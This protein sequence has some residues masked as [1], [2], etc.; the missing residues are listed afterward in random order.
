MELDNFSSQMAQSAIDIV[1]PVLENALVLSG[2]YARACGRDIILG[3]DLEYC[4][5]Y[6]AMNT[7]GDR[8]GSHFPEIYTNENS[9][10]DD[11]DEDGEY[12]VDTVDDEDELFE[13][14]SGDDV[15]FKLIND[16]YNAWETWTPTN[17]SE[18]MIKNAIDSNENM[19]HSRGME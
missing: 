15:K 13:P 5:K 2:H 16:A 7:V 6:C 14:Y 8:I 17:P 12:D 19:S 4:M 11:D 3:K 10:S 18:E 9:D 1:T